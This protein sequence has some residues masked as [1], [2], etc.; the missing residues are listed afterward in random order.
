MLVLSWFGC[1]CGGGFTY[2]WFWVVWLLR[3]SINLVVLTIVF[4]FWVDCV[5]LL[6]VVC[7]F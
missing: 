4:V 6:W 2:W 1:D 3:V 5:W 7:L